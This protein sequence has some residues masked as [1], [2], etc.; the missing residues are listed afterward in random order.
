[1]TDA[2]WLE[3]LRATGGTGAVFLGVFVIGLMR[4]W[5]VLG[6]LYSEKT[7][8]CA[9]WKVLAMR[10]TGNAG[11]AIETVSRAMETQR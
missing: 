2:Q 11:K 10:L 9:E 6:W 8:E 7:D 1:M 5:W 3:S 4:K